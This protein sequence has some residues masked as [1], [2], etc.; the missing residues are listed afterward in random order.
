MAWCIVG[1]CIATQQATPQALQQCLL[2]QV[3]AASYAEDEIQ[4]RYY[5]TPFA[6]T[7]AHE[8]PRNHQCLLLSALSRCTCRLQIMETEHLHA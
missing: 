4:T 8:Y 6:V 7:A 3:L 1:Q 5:L 2:L